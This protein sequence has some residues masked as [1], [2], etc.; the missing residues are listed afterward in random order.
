MSAPISSKNKLVPYE[1]R[2]VHTATSCGA[3]VRSISQKSK[4]D[5]GKDIIVRF[6][7]IKNPNKS[8]ISNL[9]YLLN[10]IDRPEKETTL[11]QASN[12]IN[13]PHPPKLHNQNLPEKEGNGQ[14]QLL[15]P[16][17]ASKPQ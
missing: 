10:R 15:L 14:V 6:A 2:I 13:Y 5:N 1:T 3:S 12:D 17:D 16:N 11:F 8:D 7:E 9:T 4:N